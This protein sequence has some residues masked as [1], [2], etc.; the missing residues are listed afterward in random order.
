MTHYNLT[1]T[2]NSLEIYDPIQTDEEMSSTTYSLDYPFTFLHSYHS[3]QR[4]KQRGFSKDVIKM[5]LC[6]GELIQKQGL[7]FYVGLEKTFPGHL[8]PDL[9]RKCSGMVIIV[10]D[11]QI[12]TC[13]KNTKAMR[14]IR[15]K[16][17]KN[18]KNLYTRS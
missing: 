18:I 2:A 3:Q 13:Y 6:Y 7:K 4:A 8:N 17:C 11:N 1:T 10:K 5:V 12:I 9:Q 14:N 16:T 15:K